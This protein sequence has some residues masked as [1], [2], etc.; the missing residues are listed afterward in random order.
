MTCH[1]LLSYTKSPCPELRCPTAKCQYY[2]K[3]LQ[4]SISWIWDQ[5]SPM[6]CPLAGWSLSSL[7]VWLYNFWATLIWEI[8]LISHWNLCLPILF[9]KK[10]HLAALGL[11][12]CLMI[13][14]RHICSR[15]HQSLLL[16]AIP[17]TQDCQLPFTTNFTVVLLIKKFLCNYSF[18]KSSITRL[19]KKIVC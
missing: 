6:A 19:T 12:S 13:W 4:S 5:R 15:L 7:D 18:L 11:H 16:P 10:S 1:L 17:L 3:K 14:T 8:N 2:H 9:K